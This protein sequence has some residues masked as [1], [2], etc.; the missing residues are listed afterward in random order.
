MEIQYGH[1]EKAL[2]DVV[3]VKPKA[4]GAFR[5]K[6]RHLRNIGVPQ[7]PNPGSGNAISYSQRQALEMLIALELEK[8]GFSPRNVALMAP[9]IT[10]Q[11]PYGQH[12]GQDFY[13]ALSEG[14]LTYTALGRA[15]FGEYL[16]G[17]PDVF[18]VINVSACMRK[19]NAA[20]DQ[21]RDHYKR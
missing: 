1:I 2:A 20:L 8:L 13:I 19:L 15:S 11:S 5:A 7:L 17:A 4:L 10:R 9:S 3:G 14:A 16:E 6:L 18:A 12:D 21:A